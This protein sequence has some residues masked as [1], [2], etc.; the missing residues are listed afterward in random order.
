MR[1]CVRRVLACLAFSV[2]PLTFGCDVDAIGLQVGDVVKAGVKTTVIDIGTTI[3]EAA[4]E[5]W[6]Q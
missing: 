3:V 6:F 4:V 5:P 2:C 1:T